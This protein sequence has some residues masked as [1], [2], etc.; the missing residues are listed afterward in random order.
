MPTAVQLAGAAFVNPLFKPLPT[1]AGITAWSYWG[2]SL[3]LSQNVITAGGAYTNFGPGPTWS[4]NYGHCV[5]GVSQIQTAIA[6][7]GPA[8]TFLSVARFVAGGTGAFASLAAQGSVVPSLSSV[9]TQVTAAGVASPTAVTLAGTTTVFKF[10]AW[11][12]GG[13]NAAFVYNLTDNT[14]ATGG[15]AGNITGGATLYT[16]GGGAAGGNTNQCDIAFLA[17]YN[18]F[19]SKANIDLIYAHVKDVMTARG[20]TV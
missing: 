15:T 8:Q 19:V 6:G 20:I 17:H 9:Q 4:A 12:A 14:N 11:E 13:G 16:F 18:A 3:A 10:Y 1:I 5:Y 2:G 7:N